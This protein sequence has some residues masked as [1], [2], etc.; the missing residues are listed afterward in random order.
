MFA[1]EQQNI[2]NKKEKLLP[3]MS[4][5]NKSPRGNWFLVGH[6]RDH[7]GCRPERGR[8]ALPVT[9]ANIHRKHM[10]GKLKHEKK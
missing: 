2:V 5:R 7:R 1:L 3:E 10:K 4:M 9:V 6:N 8:N